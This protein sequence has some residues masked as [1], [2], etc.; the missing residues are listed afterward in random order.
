MKKHLIFLII[1]LAFVG[2]ATTVLLPADNHAGSSSP[3]PISNKRPDAQSDKNTAI[4]LMSWNLEW[5]TLT[6]FKYAPPRDTAD[7]QALARIFADVSPDVL[8]FQEVDSLDALY[9]VVPRTDYQFFLSDRKSKTAERFKDVNQYTGFAVRNGL[10]VKD[11]KDLSSV[12]R[13]LEGKPSKLRYASYITLQSS[14]STQ[15]VHLLSI[16]LKS[17]C[18][19]INKTHLSQ[20]KTTNKKATACQIFIHQL[21]TLAQWIED[22]SDQYLIIAGDFNYRLSHENTW[23]QAQLNRSGQ[24][25]RSLT[26]STPADCYI[27]Q[28]RKGKIH[29]RSYKHL[30]DHI[31][32]SEPLVELHEHTPILAIQYPF[33]K[34]DVRQYQLTDHCP[35]ISQIQI[36]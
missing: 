11:I 23:L 24:K 9:K 32:I 22:H 27:K 29:Y 17:G 4:T 3:Q 20:T 8:A 7:Y 10:I 21:S 5:L 16:H 15:P 19:K 1:G 31:F 33:P 14:P 35:I 30:I 18:Y 36:P 34:A 13:N 26:L 28:K 25:V 6:P 12:N 2:I